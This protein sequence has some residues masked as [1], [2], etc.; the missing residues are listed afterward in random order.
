MKAL[1]VKQPWSG[2]IAIGRKTAEIRSRFIRPLG[3]I[4]I[5]SSLQ[6]YE[7]IGRYSCNNNELWNHKNCSYSICDYYG[8]AIAVVNWYDTVRF[9]KELCELACFDPKRWP[10]DFYCI[11]ET[12]TINEWAWMFKNSRLI[13]PFL[14]KGKLGLFEVDDNLIEYL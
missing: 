1:S 2:N 8:R 7:N 9:T 14:V 11:S 12:E 4:L 6:P 5:C 3:D 10:F 13:K